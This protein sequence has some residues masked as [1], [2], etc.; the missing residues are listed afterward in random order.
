MTTEGLPTGYGGMGSDDVLLKGEF[1][2]HT[3]G[4]L[5]RSRRLLDEAYREADRQGDGPRLARAALGLGGVWVHEHRAAAEAGVVRARQLHALSVID[6]RS[7][8]ALRLR[9]RLCAEDDYRSGR[10][11]RILE[12]L[13]QVRG[14]GDPVALAEALS[15]AHH[16][17]LGP[18]E[19]AIRLE[20]AEE[21]ISQAAHTARRG[22]LL[23]GLMWRT[24]DLF[25][26]ADPHAERS[27]TELRSVLAGGEHLAVGF[28]A[29]AMEVMLSIRAGRFA[30]AE[31]MAATCAERGDLAGDVDALGWYCEHL[32]TIRWY[33]GRI[34]ELVGVIS[35]LAHSPIHSAV[36]STYLAALAVAAATAG[37]HRLAVHMLARVLGRDL[38]DLPHSSSW[39]PT[40]YC[41]VEAAYLLHDTE[42]AAHAYTLLSPFADLPVISSLGVTCLGSVHHSL[43][44]SALT[45]GDADRAIDHFR[46]AIRANQALGHWPA[47]ILSR[48]RLGHA[49]ARGHGS[50]HGEARRE[51]ARAEQEAL[52]LGMELPSEKDPPAEDAVAICTCRRRGRAWQ[53]ELQGRTVVVEN[54]IGMRHLATLIA[55]PGREIPAADLAVGAGPA[56]HDSFSSQPIIDSVAKR[57]FTDRLA[58]LQEDID[59]SESMN[60]LER[61]TSLRRER[62]WLIDELTTATG[63]KGRMR[64]FTGSDERARVAV[65]KAVKRA[66]SRIT[67]IDPVVGAH[68]DE[69]VETGHRCCYRPRS[70]RHGA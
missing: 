5:R 60:D 11:D 55:N 27:L 6:P 7:S 31:S 28:V 59:D 42:A 70:D 33:Q 47:A 29:S 24:A 1:A 53:I 62:D 16:C 40:M 69:T 66:I 10:H 39:L 19:G 21:L 56:P 52:S 57:T 30:Q 48:W 68:L 20:L 25:L 17:V 34:G 12:I 37:E 41:V 58:Q 46:K 43:A 8:L 22:D 4:D 14:T 9:V 64:E 38:S 23:M 3:R 63:L 18:A 35:D 51:L 26:A 49:L 45:V 44:T 2:L 67:E 65:S 13:A 61:A 32:G 15:L 50:G 36:D 54:R